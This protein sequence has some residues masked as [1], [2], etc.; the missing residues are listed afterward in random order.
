[1]LDKA[2]TILRTG[3]NTDAVSNEQVQV[4]IEERLDP[5]Y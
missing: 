1:M 4:L 2:A 5:A 3:Q